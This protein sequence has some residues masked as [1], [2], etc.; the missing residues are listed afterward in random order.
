M[1]V[2]CC[3]GVCGEGDG[4]LEGVD[5][6]GELVVW[7]TGGHGWCCGLVL[8]AEEGR[9]GRWEGLRRFAWRKGCGRTKVWPRG[10]WFGLDARYLRAVGPIFL[11][12]SFPPRVASNLPMID[13]IAPK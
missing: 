1:D 13:P 4:E 11:P 2:D 6:W 8:C 9:W 7:R 12:Y 3:V 10:A 5:G